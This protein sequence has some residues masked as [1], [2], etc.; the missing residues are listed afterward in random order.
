MSALHIS[1]IQQPANQNCQSYG[2]LGYFMF[3]NQLALKFSTMIN[4]VGLAKA[5]GM[6]T[7]DFTQLVLVPEA[8]ILL[9]QKRLHGMSRESALK[10]RA[11]SVE[12]GRF[13]FPQED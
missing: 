1:L 2:D 6:S 4:D 10:L 5:S 8:C 11:E 9:F 7:L 3:S 13:M 12:Y